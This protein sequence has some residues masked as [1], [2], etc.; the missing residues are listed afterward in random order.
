MDKT[1]KNELY[2]T[3]EQRMDTFGS[4]K[5]NDVTFWMSIKRSYKDYEQNGNH[6]YYEPA[7]QY[8]VKWLEEHW[9]VKIYVSDN[10]NYSREYNIISPDKYTMFLL[11]YSQ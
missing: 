11:K 5:T 10:G 6:G 9:G 3:T 4:F 1:G 2:G 7:Q 8:F